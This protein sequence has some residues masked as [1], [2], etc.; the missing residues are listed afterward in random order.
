MDVRTLTQ[1]YC[2]AIISLPYLKLD[3]GQV[4]LCKVLLI[5][6]ETE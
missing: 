5:K 3:V 1:G 4:E 2:V 6:Q